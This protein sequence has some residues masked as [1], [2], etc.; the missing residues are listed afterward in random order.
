MF[1]GTC[2]I[3]NGNMLCGVYKN[4]LILRLG[5]E[6]AEEALNQ[7]HVKLFDITSKLMR[8]WVMIEE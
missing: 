7:N 3:L 6:Q 8:G 4:Y 2:H 5:E 1:G